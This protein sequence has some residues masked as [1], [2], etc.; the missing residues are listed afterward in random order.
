MW[1]GMGADTVQ[2][3][4]ILSIK[5]KMDDRKPLN[6]GRKQNQKKEYKNGTLKNTFIFLLMG[7]FYAFPI[8]ST[9]DPIFG[10]TLYL[11]LM[12]TWLSLM[13][14][15]DFSNILFDTRD[16]VI[17]L[18]RPVNDRTLLLSRMMHVFIYLLRI[19]LPMSLPGWITLGIK[20]GYAPALLVPFLLVLLALL[21]LFIVNTAYLILL[22]LTGP[23][24][25][26]DVI[27]YFQIAIAVVFFASAYLLPRA[28]DPERPN[29][30]SITDYAWVRFFPTYWM[31][32]CLHYINHSFAIVLAGTEWMGILA[33]ATPVIC[34]FVMIKWLAPQFARN[35]GALDITES[36]PAMKGGKVTTQQR[37][38][39][40]KLAKMLN[41]SDA[42][43]A[44]FMITWLQTARSRSFK[45]RV[46]PSFAYVPVY[47]VYLMMQKGKPLSEAWTELP[48]SPGYIL[49][50]YMCAFVMMNAM[51][52]LYI[53]EQ[54]K[55][56][57]V[58]YSA[59]LQTP[60]Q[61]LGGAFKA[62]WLKYFLPFFTI[63]S[64]FTVWKWGWHTIIDIILAMVNV[65]LFSLC[66]IR[67]GARH[68][69]F[70]TAERINQSGYRVVRAFLSMFL[71][72]ILGA[73]HYFLAKHDVIG[74]NTVLKIIFLFLS[75]GFA[76]LVWS[77]YT[78]TSW[79]AI[80][81]A[82]I[83]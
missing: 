30:L 9:K 79:A 60:G 13:L 3:K 41:Q 50:L 17:I 45:M 59:P 83:E 2:L 52:Y 67:V 25:F 10:M 7:F 51:N 1:K 33:I 20:Y 61:L 14:V 38:R 49:L 27:N 18:P 16:K 32:V 68:F 31:A 19:V 70:S 53:S 65:T 82:D 75:C 63:L 46:F 5:L 28:F 64:A 81:K 77:S 72:L 47:F 62:L 66:M 6:F 42:A 26:K 58:Y 55:A 37:T 57:W 44:G 29:G 78:G 21:A 71:I 54:Y 24:R 40:K 39:Y 8:F 80:Y 11:G 23:E 73:G 74:L 34:L 22:K 12:L 43:K 69:P 4:A 36:V 48:N 15:T 35:I 56:A 76:Y